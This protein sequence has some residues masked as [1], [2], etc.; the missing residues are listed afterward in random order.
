VAPEQLFSSDELAP[1]RY[2]IGMDFAKDDV[3]DHGEALGTTRL[4]VDDEVVAEGTMRTQV[5]MF[6][7]CGDGLCVGRDSS[8]AVS[9]AY[10]SPADLTGASVRQVEINLSDDQYID[11]EQEAMAALARE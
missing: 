9:S 3:G 10:A 11:L 8:D 1:G 5:G 4:H 7:L 2:V 6:T